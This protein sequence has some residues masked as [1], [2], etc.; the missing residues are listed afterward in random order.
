MPS[1]RRALGREQI[2]DEV[3][4]KLGTAGAPDAVSGKTVDLPAG[5]FSSLKLLATGVEGN[6]EM[7]TFTIQYA[8]GTSTSVTQGLTDW[9]SSPSLPGE[10]LAVQMPYRLAGDGTIDSNPFYLNAYSIAL[11]SAKEVRSI[12][13]PMNRNVLVFAMTLEPAH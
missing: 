13:L 8:D 4:F 6:Q 10:S 2:G 5:K 1:P 3:I 9:S 7:Q 11:D 12:S